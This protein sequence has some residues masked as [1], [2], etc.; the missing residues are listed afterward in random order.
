M[1]KKRVL[2]VEDDSFSMELVTDLLEVAGL[3]VLPAETAEEGIEIARAGDLALILMDIR[4][5]GIDGLVATSILKDDPR[6]TNI[7]VVALTAS[8]MRGDERKCLEA[9]CTGY[10]AKPINTREFAKTVAAYM[11]PV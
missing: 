5:P 3:E 10:I 4:L 6:T 1:K 11:S 2:V 8:T 7:P 9:G